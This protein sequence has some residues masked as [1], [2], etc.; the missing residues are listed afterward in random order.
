MHY[1]G[2]ELVMQ[3]SANNQLL[4]RVINNQATQAMVPGQQL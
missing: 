4:L 3:Q 2:F 1:Y